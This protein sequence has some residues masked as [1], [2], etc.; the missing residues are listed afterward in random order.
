M[1]N[2]RVATILSRTDV[3]ASGVHTE[4]LN[5]REVISRIRVRFGVI[6]SSGTPTEVAAQNIPKIEIVDGSDVLFSL[7]GIQAQALDF[8]QTGRVRHNNGSYVV[9]WE[10][11]ANFY[12]NFGRRLWDPDLALDPKKFNKPQI[13]VTFDEDVATAAPTANYLSILADVFDEK[14][15]SPNGFLMSKEL[16]SYAPASNGWEFIPLPKD[17]PYRKLMIEAR[18][19]DLWLGALIGEVKLSEDNDKK[20]PLDLIVQELENWL[21]DLFPRYVEHLAVDLVDTTGI[22]VYITPTQGISINGYAYTKAGLYEAVPFGYKIYGCVSSD[23]G[24]QTIELVGDVPHGCIAIPM[25]DQNDP[26]DWWDLAGK[27]GELQIKGGSAVT[28]TYRVVTEQY[29]KY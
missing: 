22:Y 2:Q 4:D 21:R 24:H 9:P 19:A 15:V 14:A 8:Y 11:I 6:N 23:I 7:S 25:G 12:I 20:V 28:G 29:R 17:W 3:G 16:Y 5:L 10:L 18:A 26:T 1:A 27:S 13:K